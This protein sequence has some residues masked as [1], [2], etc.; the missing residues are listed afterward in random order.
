[1]VNHSNPRRT[2]K[3]VRKPLTK[4]TTIL[5]SEKAGGG[6]SLRRKRIYK[7]VQINK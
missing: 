3:I 5:P 4:N 1:M 2:M 6:E 7:F